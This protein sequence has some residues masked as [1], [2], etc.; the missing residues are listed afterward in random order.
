MFTSKLTLAA[1]SFLSAV[2]SVN[3]HGYVQEVVNAGTT[4][5]GY[6]PNTDPYY[7][8]P[9]QRIVRKIPGNGPVTDLSLIDVQCNGYTEGGTPGSAPA[10]TYATVAAGSQIALNWTTWPDTHMGPMITY[11]ARAPSDITAWSPGTD[12]VWFK[13]HEIGKDA[14]GLW[15][16]TDI[17]T[18]NDSIYTFTVPANLK[19]GQ[20]LIRHEIIALHAA[21]TYPGAQVYPSC[22]Q[23]EVTGSGTALPT[24]FVSFPGAYTATTPGIVFDAYQNTGAYPIPGPS[25]WTG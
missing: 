16:A 15:A 25:V 13:V 9:P 17:L 8:P 22:I 11:M 2:A 23:I 20:Y 18:A 6:N 1:V 4:Y 7:N 5:P 21:Y 14:N 3:A 10:P 12:A 24:S 19:A